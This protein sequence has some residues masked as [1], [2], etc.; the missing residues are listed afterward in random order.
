MTLVNAEPLYID[1]PTAADRLQVSIRT[2]IRW[3]KAGQL[4]AYVIGSS[5]RYAAADVAALAER[6]NTPQRRA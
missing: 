3:E 4:P 6:R 5:I 1:R 2:V